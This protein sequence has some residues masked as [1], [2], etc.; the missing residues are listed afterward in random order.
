MNIFVGFFLDF[1][2]SEISI[3]KENCDEFIGQLREESAVY[4]RALNQFKNSRDS[5]EFLVWRYP[6][7]K[8]QMFNI[9][10]LPEKSFY[11]DDSNKMGLKKM[12]KESSST[13][14]SSPS[15]DLIFS[16]ILFFFQ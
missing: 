5:L 1:Y 13:V 10:Q 6:W 2:S 12:L 16:G 14:A 8:G 4:H 11:F 9:Q 3:H 15:E 7:I